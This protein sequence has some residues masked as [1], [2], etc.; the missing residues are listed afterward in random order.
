MRWPTDDNR[1]LQQP[2]HQMIRPRRP[3]CP[4]NSAAEGPVMRHSRETNGLRE[5]ENR[6][7]LRLLGQEWIE[8]AFIPDRGRR[9]V[10]RVHDRYI[11]ERQQPMPDI[12]N[13]QVAI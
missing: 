10:A 12:L 2:L 1:A 6:L 13:Q 4:A 8:L 5:A 7:P 9:A 11:R 3:A